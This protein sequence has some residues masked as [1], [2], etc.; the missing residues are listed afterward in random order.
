MASEKYEC[1]CPDP[2]S[3]CMEDAGQPMFVERR[4]KRK[5]LHIDVSKNDLVIAVSKTLTSR[6]HLTRDIG[7]D[8]YS[9]TRPHQRY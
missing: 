6:E 5:S 8:T 1:V 2:K 9:Q 7:P 3:R 4:L